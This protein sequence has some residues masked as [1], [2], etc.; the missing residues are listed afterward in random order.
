MQADALSGQGSSL[1][2]VKV[3]LLNTSLM[4]AIAF[5]VREIC[6]VSWLDAIKKQRFP[7]IHL[8]LWRRVCVRFFLAKLF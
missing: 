6:L 7:R 3:I 1:F 4:K 2:V 5:K 8:Y